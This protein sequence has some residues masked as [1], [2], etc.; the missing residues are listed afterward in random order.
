MTNEFA[1]VEEAKLPANLDA[2]L[3]RR[4]SARLRPKIILNPSPHGNRQRF[5]LSHELAHLR[6]PWQIGT[7]WCH[8]DWCH[9]DW[10]S[11]VDKG[12][13]FATEANWFAASLL[14]PPSW[15]RVIA[16]SEAEIDENNFLTLPDSMSGG[17]SLRAMPREGGFGAS[18]HGIAFG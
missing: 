11:Q 15:L 8:T 9:T 2:I 17:E 18:R 5:T 6:L 16:N 10:A 13:H 7:D 12:I 1:D 4:A 3:I 14:M